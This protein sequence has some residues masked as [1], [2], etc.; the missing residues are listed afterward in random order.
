MKKKEDYVNNFKIL[1]YGNGRNDIMNNRVICVD[2]QISIFGNF[3]VEIIKI[4]RSSVHKKDNK[5]NYF[6]SL[7]T[8]SF[9]FKI[10][11]YVY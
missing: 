1:L 10:L 8:G 3:G 7:I 6:L 5:L 2:C 4:G 11:S 9:E